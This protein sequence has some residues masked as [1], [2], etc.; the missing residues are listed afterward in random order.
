MV[1]VLVP[2]HNEVLLCFLDSQISNRLC[3]LSWYIYVSEIL[4]GLSILAVLISKTGQ[5]WA[6]LDVNPLHRL[7]SSSW[8]RSCSNTIQTI[9]NRRR[10]ILKNHWRVRDRMLSG[11]EGRRL[12]VLMLL[13][14]DNFSYVCVS[15]GC[16]R[17]TVIILRR[18]R[19]ILTLIGMQMLG[20]WGWWIMRGD[21]L[22]ISFK[23]IILI[24]FINRSLCLFNWLLDSLRDWSLSFFLCIFSWRLL[25]ISLCRDNSWNLTLI[26]S[27]SF[28][29]NTPSILFVLD[30]S[31][32]LHCN[33]LSVIIIL[34]LMLILSQ[35]WSYSSYY[36]LVIRFARFFSSSVFL[37]LTRLIYG[38]SHLLLL[39]LISIWCILRSFFLILAGLLIF[40]LR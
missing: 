39:L 25:L 7:Y 36:L 37:L 23:L 24:F 29:C 16:R 35:I 19:A 32:N 40:N 30:L 15:L 18:W 4:S 31:W 26:S 28:R 13:V 6:L 14:R 12:L 5:R 20:F 1:I 33:I 22:I 8:I 10:T 2:T 3:S 17:C 11:R 21:R 9:V 38:W 34:T 27:W